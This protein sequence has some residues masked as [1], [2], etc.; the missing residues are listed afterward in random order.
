MVPG[1]GGRVCTFVGGTDLDQQDYYMSEIPSIFREIRWC[2]SGQ[3]PDDPVW[4]VGSR[5]GV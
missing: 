2:G 3:D 1:L 5:K 4:D